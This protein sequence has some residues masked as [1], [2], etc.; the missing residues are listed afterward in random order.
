MSN[1][2][3]TDRIRD[4]VPGLNDSE[5]ANLQSVKYCRD[6]FLINYSVLKPVP[7][8]SNQEQ[9]RTE[10]QVNGHNR[11]S[12]QRPIIRNNECFLVT[13]QWTDRHRL[14]FKNWLEEINA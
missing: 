4:I 5:V 1:S 9:I 6:T 14:K 12:T 10:A 8:H 13:T 7:M 2:Q 3:I 11:W